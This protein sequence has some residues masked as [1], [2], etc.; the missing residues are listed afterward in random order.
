MGKMAAKFL[1]VASV[2]AFSSVNVAQAQSLRSDDGPAEFPGAG[3]TASQYVDSRGCMFIRAGYGGNTVW[4]PQVSRDRKLLCGFTPSGVTRAS[5]T[6]TTSATT[7]TLAPMTAP[8]RTTAATTNV[9]AVTGVIAPARRAAT[10]VM[11]AGFRAA[12]NDGRLNKHRGP[13]TELGDS[14]MAMVW[15]NTVPRKLVPANQ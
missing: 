5:S 15:T 9:I 3:Y 10:A 12:W 4:V 14:Q 1:I 2:V 8:V 6:S 7:S 13:Q 11:P